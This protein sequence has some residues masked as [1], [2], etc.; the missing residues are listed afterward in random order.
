MSKTP[1]A[2]KIKRIAYAMGQWYGDHN[3]KTGAQVRGPVWRGR[4]PRHADP[5]DWEKVAAG[6]HF[7]ANQAIE[8]KRYPAMGFMPD[9]GLGRILLD[10]R[11][12]RR[13]RRLLLSTIQAPPSRRRDRNERRVERM[14]TA[15]GITPA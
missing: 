10:R 9:S 4:R 13:T 2:K 3:P 12:T 1:S 7:E 15:V 8:A 14:L 6:P 11:V 5:V